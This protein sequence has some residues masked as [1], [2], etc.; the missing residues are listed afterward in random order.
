MR[1]S[2]AEIARMLA[3]SERAV[4]NDV[5]IGLVKPE[6]GEH[7]GWRFSFTDLV[8]L[9]SA[10]DLRA[11]NVSPAAVSR[12]L[13]R[14]RSELPSSL[15]AAGLRIAMVGES[16]VVR[17]GDDPWQARGG[18]YLLEL[19][20]ARLGDTVSFTPRAPRD[21]TRTERLYA[22]AWAMEERDPRGAMRAYQLLLQSVPSH[23]AAA[24][25]LGR[26]LHAAGHLREALEVYEA[27]LAVGDDALVRFNAGVAL[28]DLGRFDDALRS[29]EAA[30]SLDPALVDAHFNAALLC[31]STG[32]RSGTLRHMAGYRRGTR[33]R[34]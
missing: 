16:V 1:F 29:Y 4:R 3:L 18:Q 30:L 28:E 19:D 10:R 23:A 26:L 17:A 33:T 11:A 15:P 32:D 9:R 7:N 27:F 2:T 20:V 8:V 12:A 6:R 5:R 31:E 25:N 22:Q 21:D 14:L 13:A 24:A 34:D